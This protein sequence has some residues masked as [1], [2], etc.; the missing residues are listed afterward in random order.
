MKITIRI[1]TLV[2]SVL[3]ITGTVL[4]G[5]CTCSQTGNHEAKNIT[6]EQAPAPVED[7][8]ISEN[9]TPQ[10]A[11]LLIQENQGNPDFVII[12]VRTPK[13]F[14]EGHIENSINIDF[15]RDTFRDELDNMDKEKTYIIY[16]RSANRSYLGAQLLINNGFPGIIYNMAGGI[17][18]WKAEGLPTVKGFGFGS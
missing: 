17:N 9:I 16:C 10:Q 15:Y 18:A 12:D 7:I 8:Q 6:P 1:T 4:V 3:L 11:Y 14:N 2:L 13:E 5:A